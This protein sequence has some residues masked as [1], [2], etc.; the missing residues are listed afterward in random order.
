MTQEEKILRHLQMYGSIT[1]IEALSEYSCMRLASRISDLKRC[2]YP[3]AKEM[4]TS[5]NRLGEPVR[6]AKYTLAEEHNA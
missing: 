4:Q 5:K 2:G 3:I 6:Y 1:P